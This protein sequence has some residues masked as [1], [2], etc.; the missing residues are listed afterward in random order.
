[1]KRVYE[2][3]AWS[4]P[5][6]LLPPEYGKDILQKEIWQQGIPKDVFLGMSAIPDPIDCRNLKLAIESG[7]ITNERFREF[8]SEY[9]MSDDL[10]SE[11]SAARFL[12]YVNGRC[13]AW[14]H[15]PEDEVSAL[16][17]IIVKILAERGHIVIDPESGV[18]I[19]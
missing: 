7:E 11:E 9:A 4:V 2:L 10:E 19:S 14:I 8:C 15:L 13:L 5:G 16:L 18:A 6:K 1:M 17:P 3:E 12:E